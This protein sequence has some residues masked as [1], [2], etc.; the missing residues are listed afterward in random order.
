[1][2]CGAVR[3][4]TAPQIRYFLML[5]EDVPSALVLLYEMQ[6]SLRSDVMQAEGIVSLYNGIH[7]TLQEEEWPLVRSAVDVRRASHSLCVCVSASLCLC[8][9]S[10][11]LA[12]VSVSFECV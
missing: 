4:L 6:G 7:V 1:M 10:S 12:I 11:L 9:I 3:A 8:T 5:K 2:R